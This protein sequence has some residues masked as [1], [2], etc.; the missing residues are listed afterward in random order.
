MSR[1]VLNAFRVD[2]RS[3]LS[4]NLC[5]LYLIVIIYNGQH[6]PFLYLL[7]VMS[8]HSLFQRKVR[9][10]IPGKVTKYGVVSSNSLY[11]DVNKNFKNTM[12]YKI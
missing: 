3:F 8:A 4:L 6:E 2:V 7:S 11:Y 9:V 1:M 5:T 10:R 12:T